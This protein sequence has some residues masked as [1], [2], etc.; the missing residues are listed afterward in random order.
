M[1]GFWLAGL[2]VA[3]GAVVGTAVGAEVQTAAGFTREGGEPLGSDAAVINAIFDEAVLAGEQMS[4]IVELDGN[5]S[6]VF[7]VASYQEASRQPLDDVRDDIAGALRTARAEE[8]MAARADEMIAAIDAGSAFAD[9]AAAINARVVEPTL[10]SRSDTGSDRFLSAAV[11]AAAKPSADSSTIGS[12]RND[13]GG[14][15]VYSVEA[16]LPGR[17]EMLP[18]EQR[19]EGKVQLTRQAGIG[20]YNAFVQALR[21]DAEVIINE[22]AVAANESF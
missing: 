8:L 2:G 15:T 20:D 18:V 13:A 5:R 6:A 9:A 14:Y 21:E 16:V 7:F 17:P 10:M 19:D 1:D 12:T 4:E 22:D 3:A 11:F